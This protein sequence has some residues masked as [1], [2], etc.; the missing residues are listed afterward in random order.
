VGGNTTVFK[1]I[2]Y[3]VIN[4][5]I[6]GAKGKRQKAKGKRQKEEGGRHKA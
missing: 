3:K 5:I 1:Y 6:L 4:Q 2:F